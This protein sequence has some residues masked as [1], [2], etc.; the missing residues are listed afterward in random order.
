M[1]DYR[2]N[3]LVV[4]RG[5]LGLGYSGEVA[6]GGFEAIESLRAHHFNLVLMD[7]E[8][9][10]MDGYKATAEFRRIEA[11]AGYGERTPVVAMTGD[12]TEG[13]PDRCVAAGIDDYLAKPVRMEALRAALERWVPKK[14]DLL[15]AQGG[16]GIHS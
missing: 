6:A 12:A 15:V 8:M 2:V 13:D 10:G 1:D 9:P 3:Q 11:L 5:V 4:L 16:R 14:R 7:S